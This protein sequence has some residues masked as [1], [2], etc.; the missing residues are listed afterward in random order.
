MMKRRACRSSSVV[1]LLALVACGGAKEA[2]SGG[3]AAAKV[4]GAAAQVEAAPAKDDAAAAKVEDEEAE[5]EA[6][7]AEASVDA[8]AVQAVV[9]AWLAAQNGG[10]FAAYERL[11][12]AKMEGVKRA[13]PRTSRFDRAGWLADRQKMFAGKPMTVGIRDVQIGGSAAAPTVRFVQTFRKGKFADEGPKQLVLSRGPSGGLTIA[14]EEMLAS[15]IGE[16]APASAA[17]IWLVT[18]VDGRPQV[19]I[20]ADADPAWGRGAIRGPFGDAPML[21]TRSASGAPQKEAWTG[22]RVAVYSATG[23]R[24]EAKVGAL[25]LVGGGT[26]HFGE[27]QVWDGDPAMSP[28]GRV[29]SKGERARAVFGMGGLYVM[30]ELAIDGGCAPVYAAEVGSAVTPFARAAAEEEEAAAAVRAYRALPAYAEIQR[31]WKGDFEGAGEWVATPAV[32][33][34]AAGERK[35]VV[36]SAHEG[37]GCGGFEGELTAVFAEEGGTLALVSDPAAGALEV[38]AMVDGDGD[39]KAEI[40]GRTGDWSVVWSYL[41]P[42]SEGFTTAT[43]VVFPFKDCGC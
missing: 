4:E 39:G 21:A 30:G 37:S 8:A 28:D 16:A 15:T 9:D 31:S 12:A 41:V 14:R 18:T 3:G 19:V 34:F 10:D 35:Y 40:V 25:R 32:S 26:P 5:G 22:K 42:G 17:A 7:P 23:E 13:G 6:L 43:S 20:A 11:Y 29:W 38:E 2:G 1:V 27:V 24:C 33:T 36:V